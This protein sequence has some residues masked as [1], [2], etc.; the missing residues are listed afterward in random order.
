MLELDPAL[1]G[2]ETGRT[3]DVEGLI[4]GWESNSRVDIRSLVQRLDEIYCGPVAAE[5]LHL[6]VSFFKICAYFA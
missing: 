5:F 3:Y 2:I 1:Y 6:E 4:S